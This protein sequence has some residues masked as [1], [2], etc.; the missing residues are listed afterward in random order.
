MARIPVVTD[1]DEKKSGSLTVRKAPGDESSWAMVEQQAEWHPHHTSGKSRA[2]YTCRWTQTRHSGLV[3]YCSNVSEENR[4]RDYGFYTISYTSKK[5][6]KLGSSPASHGQ[7]PKGGELENSIIRMSQPG[8]LSTILSRFDKLTFLAVKRPKISDPGRYSY[9]L[10][11]EV[12][13][14]DMLVVPKL[15]M[16]F[17]CNN[18]IYC[19][20]GSK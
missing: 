12:L 13:S 19:T 9:P 14:F 6:L 4:E 2:L 10:E 16:T 17:D 3:V 15:A 20:F 1:N 18:F 7:M 8:S 11:P 5:C